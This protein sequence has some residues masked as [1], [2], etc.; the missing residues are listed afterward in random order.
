MTPLLP[1]STIG[2]LGGGQLG[3]M[4][5]LAARRMGYRTAVLEPGND[6]PAGQV[7]DVHVSGAYADLDAVDRLARLSDVI[8]LEFENMPVAVVERLAEARPTRPG[9][10]AL[11]VAQ[12]RMA[13]KA[14]AQGLELDVAPYVSLFEKGAVAA[15]FEQLG[16]EAILKSARLGYDGKGQRRVRSAAEAVAAFEA[17]GRQPCVLEQVVPFEREI[18]V[19]VARDVHGQVLTWTPAENQH[20]GGILDVSMTPARISPERAAE[21]QRM[22]TLV[23]QALDFIGVMALELFQTAD[24]RL[25]VNELAPRPHNSGHWSIEACVTSQFEQQVRAVI[26][27]SLGP[28][29]LLSPAATVNL[30]GDLWASGEPHWERLLEMPDVKLHLYGKREPRP[31]RKIGHLTVLAAT[32]EAA[33]ARALEA[34]S[35]I[36][37]GVRA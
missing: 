26:G 35:R 32:A 8:T 25:L 5:A 36:V 34:R 22:A 12:D 28:T 21:A 15:G 37:S 20:V 27:A 11:R 16:G 33:R 24:G 6:C 3:R 30:M 9:A 2:I 29:T 17:L 13:E 19:L 18:S 1:G 4:T 7:C 10:R 14:F 31:G 23:A